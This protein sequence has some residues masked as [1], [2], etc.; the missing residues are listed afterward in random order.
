MV[1]STGKNIYFYII[2]KC[3]KMSTEITV[4]ETMSKAAKP[5][6]S[7]EIAEMTGIDKKDVDKAIKLLKSEEKIISPKVCYYTVK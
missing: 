5:L 3:K 6:K 1:N 7:A 2:I 4:L